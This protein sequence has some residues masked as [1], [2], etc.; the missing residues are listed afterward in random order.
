MRDFT[1]REIHVGDIIL[2]SKTFLRSSVLNIGIVKKIIGGREHKISAKT[3]SY[4]QLDRGRLDP[5]TTLTATNS[6]FSNCET[7]CF[8]IEPHQVP[9]GFRDFIEKTRR[10]VYESTNGN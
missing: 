9:E 5:N 10:E 7:K 4:W 6:T 3:F 8:I 2:Y 1:G